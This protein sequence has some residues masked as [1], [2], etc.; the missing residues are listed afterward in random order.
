MGGKG[1]ANPAFRW[2]VWSEPMGT[3]IE[4]EHRKEWC[5]RYARR[6]NDAVHKHFQFQKMASDK[7]EQDLRDQITELQNIVVRQSNKLAA[8]EKDLADAA[9][10]LKVPLPEP[11][12]MVAKLLHAN[13]MLRKNY[14]R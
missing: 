2:G 6:I 10:E 13:V 9:G 5:I 14:P 4:G 12:S 3:W 7:V 8:H 11:G 1:E